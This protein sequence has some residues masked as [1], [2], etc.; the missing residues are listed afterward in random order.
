MCEGLQIFLDL[1][2]QKIKSSTANE[3][4]SIAKKISIYKLNKPHSRA[5]KPHIDNGMTQITK[6]HKFKLEKTVKYFATP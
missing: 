4:T 1:W 5:H 2:P 3:Y 6:C